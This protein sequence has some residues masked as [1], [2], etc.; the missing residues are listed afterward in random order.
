MPVAFV[1]PTCGAAASFEN[2]PFEFCP[3]CAS[4]LPAALQEQLQLALGSQ[5]PLPLTIGMVL[6]GALG[7]F[8][9]GLTALAPFNLGTYSINGKTV[10]GPEFLRQ[11]GTVWTVGG[12]LCLVIAYG[13]YRER[14]WTRALMLAFWVVIGALTFATKMSKG[15]A[16]DLVSSIAWTV[17]CLGTTGAYLYAKTN[18]VDY[19]RALE[20]RSR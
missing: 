10:T 6:S 17:F 7:A 14:P 4:P 9:V 13:L 3:K 2:R 5:R 18:V 1:C 19:Y 8:S 12:L 16:G 15:S 20:R 11:V